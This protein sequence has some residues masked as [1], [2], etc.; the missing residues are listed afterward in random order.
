MDKSNFLD[1]LIKIY[2]EDFNELKKRDN[3]ISEI[4]FINHHALPQFE[5][6]FEEKLSGEPFEERFSY[7]RMADY[8]K[9]RV[10]ELQQAEAIKSNGISDIDFYTKI[11]TSL[12]TGNMKIG[13]TKFSDAF[14]FIEAKHQEAQFKGEVYY[15]NLL[16]EMPNH[17][18]AKLRNEIFH[19]VIAYCKEKIDLAKNQKGQL[20]YL[21]AVDKTVC[22]VQLDN[23]GLRIAR[24][25]LK[26][27]L[28]CLDEVNS[29]NEVVKPATEKNY[30]SHFYIKISKVKLYEL[31]DFLD[32]HYS[33]SN[34]QNRFLN[35]LKALLAC[36][37]KRHP[38]SAEFVSNWL[39]S[40]LESSKPE[41]V[42]SP[43]SSEKKKSISLTPLQKE[44]LKNV[45]DKLH[46][47]DLIGKEVKVP[48]FK[49]VFISE[50]INDKI[51]WIGSIAALRFF[52]VEVCRV[53]NYKG[54]KWAFT[55]NSFFIKG[56]PLTK[57]ILQNNKQVGSKDRENIKKAVTHLQ[58][59][60]NK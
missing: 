23:G 8:L 37:L 30:I 46:S 18:G 10:T 27:Y 35:V 20:G 12:Y 28:D 34:D 26:F 6:L 44:N 11:A 55:L 43:R 53:S 13:G 48:A 21:F 32:C 31:N 47:A 52:I 5:K 2:N 3:S 33:A 16:H 14:K 15:E 38:A 25:Q 24:T 54:E 17:W 45:L 59:T 36:E 42:N 41:I 4:D 22:P 7:K 56:K 39:N 1:G 9:N 40:K 58:N 57:Q 29:R 51:E 60:T 50:S 49:K 19:E